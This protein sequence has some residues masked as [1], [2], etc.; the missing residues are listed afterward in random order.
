MKKLLLVLTVIRKAE[1]RSLVRIVLEDAGHR[2]IESPGCSQAQALLENGLRPDLVVLE[3]SAADIASEPHR[4]LTHL[5]ARQHVCLIVGLADCSSAESALSEAAAHLLTKPVTRE[6]LE[7]MIARIGI[8]DDLDTGVAT[9][10]EEP[11]PASEDG[12]SPRVAPCIEELGDGKFFLAASP[13]MMEIHRQAKLLADVDVNVLLLGESGTGKEI[14]AHLIHLHS[15]RRQGK[16]VNVNCAAL[17]PDLL[18][19]EFFGYRQGAF[20]GAIRDRAGKFELAH[21]GT[22]LLDEIG[23]LPVHT[24]AKLLHVLQDGQ[25]TRLGGQEATCVDVRVLAAT[26]VE[27]EDALLNRTFREDLYYRLNAFTIH[28]PPLRER[29]EEIPYLIEEYVRRAPAGMRRATDSK[30]PSRLMDIA[31]LCDWR[32]NLRELRNF[33]VRTLVMRD[34]D[35]AVR[36][37]EEKIVANGSAELESPPVRAASHRPGLRSVVRDLQARTEA[38]MMK[39]ALDRFGWNR[40]QAAQY[41]QISY[42][43]LLYKIQQHRLAP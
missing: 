35:A 39:D 20:T 18:E 15:Q 34:A 17:P 2:V 11:S 13:G 25:F 19:S 29:R 10:T 16:F 33:V 8:P 28:L 40:R 3:S 32:G 4:C 21:G 7:A 24:Q 31:M 26:N 30:L 23:E 36:E 42:R 27:L 43:G 37:L 9:S 41:L 6:D 1:I 5:T 22:L 14:V 12:W 38:K